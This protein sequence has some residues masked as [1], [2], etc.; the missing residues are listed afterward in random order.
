MA[1][2]DRAE[3][4]PHFGWLVARLPAAQADQAIRGLAL[5]EELAG[6]PD[7]AGKR[8]A[9]LAKGLEKSTSPWYE[10][11]YH[12]VWC[13]ERRGG[14]DGARR[15]SAY[16]RLQRPAIADENQWEKSDELARRF[17]LEPSA[18]ASE[19]A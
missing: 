4:R 11:R 1:P 3:A 8:W 2:A 7:L 10:A 6:R 12:W 9:V 16:F 17:G 15:M 5:C 19:A 14:T 18:R 13:I